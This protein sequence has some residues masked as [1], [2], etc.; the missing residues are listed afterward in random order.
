M[1]ADTRLDAAQ[2]QSEAHSDAKAEKSSAEYDVAVEK[3]DVLAGQVKDECVASAKSRF[4][5][6]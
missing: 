5:K 2:K 6:S 1:N 4:G 3:C